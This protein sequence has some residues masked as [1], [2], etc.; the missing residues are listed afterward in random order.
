MGDLDALLRLYE[1]LSPGNA[2]VDP[3]KARLALESMLATPN[4]TLLVAD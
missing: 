3:A 2:T 1:Q 4:V